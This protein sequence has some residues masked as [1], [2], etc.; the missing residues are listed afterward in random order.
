MDKERNVVR[1]EIEQTREQLSDQLAE[2]AL[3][4]EHAQEVARNAVRPRYYVERKPWLVF[5]GAVAAGYLLTRRRADRRLLR[6]SATARVAQDAG[7]AV[8]PSAA[9]QTP[10]SAVDPTALSGA[11][12]PLREELRTAVGGI[13]RQMSALERRFE[14]REPRDRERDDG[15][16]EITRP[17]EVPRQQPPTPRREPSRIMRELAPYADVARG[18]AF[19]IGKA[20]LLQLGR[21]FAEKTLANTRF[22][23]G[24]N[25]GGERR[26]RDVEDA[27]YEEYRAD[28]EGRRP[29][30]R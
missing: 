7:P 15:F 2:L 21:D 18:A 16:D 22:G 11:I 5:A 1:G 6:Q 10:P 30:M 19:G 14:G 17:L 13:S 20:L 25:G 8:V 24:G 4:L 27:E 29:W 26:D 3:R 9:A 28:P 12:E 23:R